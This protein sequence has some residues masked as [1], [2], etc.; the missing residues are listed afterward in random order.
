[1][2]GY[3]SQSF[4]LANAHLQRRD[5]LSV[6][7][8]ES[9]GE[10]TYLVS[11][12]V[13]SNFHQLGS[14]QYAFLSA[15]DGKT[16]LEEVTGRIASEL[17][18]LALTASQA[19]QTARY[20]L[21]HQLIFAVDANGE[22]LN[23]TNRLQRQSERAAQQRKQENANPLFLKFPL[24]N[25]TRLLNAIVPWT[26]WLFAPACIVFAIALGL[27]AMARLWQNADELAV[28]LQGVISP[29]SGIWLAVTFVGLKIVHELGH[30]IACRRLG[31]TVRETGVV[32]ILFVPIPYVDVTS[33]WDFPSKQQRMLVSAAGMMVEMMVASLAA[34]AWSLSHDPVVRFHLTNWMLMGTLTTVLFNANFLMRFDGYF[35]L[36][37]AIG[38]PN[39]AALSR[40]CVQARLK[41]L[42]LGST[43]KLPAD[44]MQHQTVLMS[45]GVAAMIWRWIVCMGLAVAASKLFNGFGLI[46]AIASLVAWF[47]RPAMGI[48][49]SLVADTVEGA[50]ARRTLVRRT[51]PSLLG[52]VVLMCL[53]PWPGRVSSPAVVR[54]HQAEIV[55]AQTT[56]FVD[57]ILVQPGQFV[58]ANQPIA[59]LK[60][61]ALVTEIESLQSQVDAARIRARREWADGKIASH[62]AEV[63]VADSLQSRLNNRRERLEL[64]TIRAGSSG[65]VMLPPQTASLDDWLG[66][67]AREGTELARVVDP[68]RKELLVSIGQSDRNTFAE[69]VNEIVEFVPHSALPVTSARLE[70][71]EPTATDQTDPRLT[72]SAGGPLTEHRIATETRL[73]APRFEAV[74]K[75]DPQASIQ[76]AS[77]LTGQVRLDRRPRSI[78]GYLLMKFL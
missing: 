27:I 47:G 76:L 77:G 9:R 33:A 48:L 28:S 2:N 53:T 43:S 68:A 24:G 39:L 18:K 23:A 54:F 41:Q 10:A 31:G 7:L 30:A 49:K 67:Y 17:P 55:R 11:D 15:L 52:I 71:V 4:E 34:I 26:Q 36:S 19:E 44:M 74:V 66:R 38:I 14:A 12:G 3:D 25:P 6:R 29:T 50:S 46:L 57:Q 65:R 40:Q 70:R 56:G 13:S 37:D 22:P 21:D 5:G 61:Q 62:H 63:A 73:I 59:K 60:N 58:H 16:S 75:L 20:L 72:A 64:L 69:C 51:V 8:H 42:L 45:Y 78:A 1:M 35:L 32:F